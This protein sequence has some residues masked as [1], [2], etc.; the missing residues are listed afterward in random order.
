M[1]KKNLSVPDELRTPKKTKVEVVNF[2]N[3]TIMRATFDAGWKWS[4]CIKPVVGTDSCQVPHS[5][6]VVSGK[7]IV[8]MDNGKTAE[9]GPGD[10]AEIPPGHDAWVVGN[11]PCVSIDFAAGKIYA[12]K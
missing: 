4:D 6:Y 3:S 9:L 12:K 5:L 2:S 7:M 1:E 10:A 8:K 11:E